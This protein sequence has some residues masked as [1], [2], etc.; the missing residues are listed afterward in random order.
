MG[1]DSVGRQLCLNLVTV[2][3]ASRNTSSPA[4]GFVFLFFLSPHLPC[5]IGVT[6]KWKHRNKDEDKMVGSTPIFVYEGVVS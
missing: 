3:V 6:F 1:A 2:I 5:F 4:N